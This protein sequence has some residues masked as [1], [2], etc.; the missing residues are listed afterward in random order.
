MKEQH[1]YT[2]DLAEIRSMME[3]SSKFLS[4]SGWE[5]IMAGLYA[6]TGAWVAGSFY[7]FKPDDIFYSSNELSNILILAIVVLVLSLVTAVLF[8]RTRAM[9]S[10]DKV[11]SPTSKRLLTDMAIPLFTGGFLIVVAIFQGLIGLIAPL[12]LIFYGLALVNAGKYTIPEVKIMGLI[13]IILG[14]IGCWFIEY[15]VLLWSI[16]FGVIHIIYGIYMH[17]SYER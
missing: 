7:D 1:D 5:G 17:F 4:L 14:L 12:S 9:K 11:W 15:G 8:S 13:Q 6:L 16:G 10:G 3:R 2:Q